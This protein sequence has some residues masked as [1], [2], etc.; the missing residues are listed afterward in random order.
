[1]KKTA[2]C[3]LLCL[4][5]ALP[6]LSVAQQSQQVN[7]A[8]RIYFS[9]GTELA[10]RLNDGNLKSEI[11]CAAVAE[12]VFYIDPKGQTVDAV[13]VQYGQDM[14]PY[15]VQAQDAQG[16]WQVI[17]AY[18]E[19]YAQ[20]TRPF[21]RAVSASGWCLPWKAKS[22]P[23]PCGRSMYSPRG[24]AQLLRRVPG[25]LPAIKPICC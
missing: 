20:A 3:L 22:C 25:S 24:I 13:C 7:R 17:G 16:V 2:L 5:L 10:S 19:D 4:L 15:T 12:H 11:T 6:G 23:C 8:C 21:L 1:M 9:N 18:T 14:L